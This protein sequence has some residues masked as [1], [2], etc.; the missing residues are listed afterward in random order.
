MNR[1]T[2]EPNANSQIQ[3]LTRFRSLDFVEDQLRAGRSLAEALRQASLLPWPHEQGDFYK[4][5]TFEDWW[6]A[7]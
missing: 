1:P 3:A 6:Y 7:Y 2:P 5:R 4:P